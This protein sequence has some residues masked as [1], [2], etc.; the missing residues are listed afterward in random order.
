MDSSITD[1]QNFTGFDTRTIRKRLSEAGVVFKTGGYRNSAKVC[2]S[3]IALPILYQVN[4]P[5]NT[6]PSTKIQ[7]LN[8]YEKREDIRRKKR[9]NDIEEKL[10]ISVNAAL[11]VPEKLAAQMVPIL[12]SLP[13]IMKRNR[14]EI[15]GDEILL[16]KK[17]IAECLNI[18]DN[19]QVKID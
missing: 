5:D 6:D 12:E 4:Q 18:I 17:S 13:L 15:S 14:P 1:L 9:E 16:T 19:I 3:K 7:L 8:A 10:L 11:E 2:D